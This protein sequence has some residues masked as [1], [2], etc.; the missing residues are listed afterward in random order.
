MTA[1]TPQEARTAAVLA[2][3][4]AGRTPGEAAA[5]N[6]VSLSAVHRLAGLPTTKELLAASSEGREW[7]LIVPHVQRR[8][9]DSSRSE[10]KRP[11]F[12]LTLKG[13]PRQRRKGKAA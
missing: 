7:A 10:V 12:D 1:P 5:R 13:K 2:D 6:A 9:E 11:R 3:L 8:G 4:E